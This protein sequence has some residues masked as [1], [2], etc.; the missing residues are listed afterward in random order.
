[1]KQNAEDKYPAF[2]YDAFIWLKRS[3]SIIT[4]RGFFT[5]SLPLL[6]KVE[7]G[8]KRK[9]GFGFGLG[10]GLKTF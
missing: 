3:L 1:M 9:M 10:L 6:G 7:G 2:Q 8:R 4:P 5:L